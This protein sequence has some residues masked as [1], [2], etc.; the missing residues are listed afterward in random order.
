MVG[1]CFQKVVLQVSKQLN[2][3]NRLQMKKYLHY[4]QLLNIIQFMVLIS[5]LSFKK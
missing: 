3:L 2:A 5:L 1:Y 4:V